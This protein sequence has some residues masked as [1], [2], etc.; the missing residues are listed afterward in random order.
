LQ[1]QIAG[2]GLS[3]EHLIANA[4]AGFLTDL[5]MHRRGIRTCPLYDHQK[6]EIRL[7]AGPLEFCGDCTRKVKNPKLR[8]ALVSILKSFR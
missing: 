2:P 3:I 4:V 5:P 6:R 8:G 1:D 7:I